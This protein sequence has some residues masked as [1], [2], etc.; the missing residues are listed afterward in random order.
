MKK[1]YNAPEFLKIDIVE[2]VLSE[3]DQDNLGGDITDDD[4]DAESPNALV[5]D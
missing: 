2:D 5:A 4:Y 3:S 1:V